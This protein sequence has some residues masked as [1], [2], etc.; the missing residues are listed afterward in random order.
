MT[1]NTRK[2][3]L[4]RGLGLSSKLLLLTV[5]FVMLAEILIFVP[6]LANFRK[7]WLKQRLAEAQIA[8]LAVEAAPDNIVPEKLRQELLNNAQVHSVALKRNDIRRLILQSPMPQKIDYHCDL[9]QDSF[10]KLLM[11]ALR[12]IMSPSSKEKVFRIVGKPDFSA[13]QFIEIVIDEA[14]LKQA[15]FEFC[16]NILGL[17]ILISIITAALVYFSLNRLLVRPIL[18]LSAN[19]MHF[20]EDPEDLHRVIKPTGRLDEL[21]TAENE[22]ADMQQ[23]LS[24]MLKHKNRLAA[25]GLA[26][27]KINHDLRN[28][29]GTAHLISD[30]L[31]SVEDPTVQQ[32]TPRLIRAIDR[33]INLCSET[34]LYGQAEETEPEPS[35]FELAPLVRD[36]AMEIGLP[37]DPIIFDIDIAKDLKIFADYDK[38]YRVLFNMLRN[39]MQAIE[40]HFDRGDDIFICIRGRDDGDVSVIDIIDTGPGLSEIAA[41]H[42]FDAFKGSG[43]KGGTGLGLA[44]VAEIVR[45]HG[46][47]IKFQPSQKGAHFQIR[48]P[49]ER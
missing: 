49:H 36:I 39:S 20:R 11:D 46:G 30:R 32:V 12:V 48:L 37:K 8:I 5:G 1:T 22:L 41:T 2:K 40:G 44:I 9:R 23:N 24:S 19:M 35:W 27:S 17:S 7:N 29:L 42:L 10:W 15:M 3:G 43:R 38:F 45:A 16:L 31:Q 13:G 33:A 18:Y 21:G 4:A 47:E 26:V 28:M 25:L 14:P 6:S 34:L